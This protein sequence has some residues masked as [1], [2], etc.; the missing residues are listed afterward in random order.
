MILIVAFFPENSQSSGGSLLLETG[1]HLFDRFFF[2]NVDILDLFSVNNIN[3][4]PIG[5]D[6]LTQSV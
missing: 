6:I 4:F 3:Q 5:F 1:K 2:Y